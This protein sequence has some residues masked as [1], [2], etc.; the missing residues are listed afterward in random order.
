MNVR[1]Q[2]ILKAF[3]DLIDRNGINRT[4]MQDI[5]REM[6]CSVGT[7]YNEFANKEALIDAYASYILDLAKASAEAI[8][9]SAL[10]PLAQLRE[11]L[12]SHVV[13]PLICF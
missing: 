10:S 6:G 1:Q 12:L 13:S 5:A 7:I 9:D 3:I 11:L 8:T 4:T 2:E